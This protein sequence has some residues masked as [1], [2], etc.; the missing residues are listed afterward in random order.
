MQFVAAL[1]KLFFRKNYVNDKKQRDQNI[2]FGRWGPHFNWALLKMRSINKLTLSAHSWSSHRHR[3]PPPP[4]RP[5]PR[6]RC[7]T[8]THPPHTASPP[9]QWISLVV[10]VLIRGS[11]GF[12]W[13][14]FRGDGS[15][16]AHDGEMMGKQMNSPGSERET[17]LTSSQLILWWMEEYN[18]YITCIWNAPWKVLKIIRNLDQTLNIFSKS[19]FFTIFF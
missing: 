7:S 2:Y 19:L 15:G 8:R 17:Q 4:R 16:L 1:G 13:Q 9:L 6:T 14:V 3:P 12:H 11:L 18:V 10:V 5:P